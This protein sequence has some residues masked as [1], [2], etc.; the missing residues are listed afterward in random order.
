MRDSI[1]IP[2][3]YHRLYDDSLVLKS[4]RTQRFALSF[5]NIISGMCPSVIS[6]SRSHDIYHMSPEIVIAGYLK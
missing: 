1:N 2:Y 6:A 4:V 5:A 3:P